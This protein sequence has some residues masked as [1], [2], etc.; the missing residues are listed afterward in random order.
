MYNSDYVAQTNWFMKSRKFYRG[1]WTVWNLYGKADET[2]D[3]Q[4]ETSGYNRDEPLRI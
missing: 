2:V 3:Y 1:S 4:A